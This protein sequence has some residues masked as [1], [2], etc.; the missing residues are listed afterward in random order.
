MGR[1]NSKSDDD[2]D[3]DDAAAHDDDDDDDDDMSENKLTLGAFAG[4]LHLSE[5]I[6]PKS[7]LM[8]VVP[9]KP[10]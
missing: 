1:S 2:D 8:L 10:T 9:A 7:I 4:C 6:P 5:G 3:D